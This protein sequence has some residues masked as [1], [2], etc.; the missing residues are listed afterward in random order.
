MN[1][2]KPRV[3]D[4]LYKW[5]NENKIPQIK[6]GMVEDLEQFLA[7]IQS[8]EESEKAAQRLASRVETASEKASE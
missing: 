7:E 2:T 8:Q 1:N 3:L 6:K 5:V 4:F